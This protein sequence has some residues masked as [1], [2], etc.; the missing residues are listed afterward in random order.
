MASSCGR[1]RMVWDPMSA[2]LDEEADSPQAPHCLPQ[3]RGLAAPGD[4]LGDEFRI[5]AHAPD[6]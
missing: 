2:L 1:G 6:E 4:V 5:L 3:Q